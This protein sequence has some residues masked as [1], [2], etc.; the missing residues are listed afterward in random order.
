[1]GYSV[2]FSGT[3]L[4]VVFLVSGVGKWFGYATFVASIRELRVLP[5]SA[6]PRAA[7]LVIAAEL[8]IASTLAAGMMVEPALRAYAF[9]LAALM[10]AGFTAVIVITLRRGGSGG[11]AC[12][13]R[14]SSEFS[15]R[16]L[17]RNAVL[18]VAALAG[19]V[20]AREDLG[21]WTAG[22]AVAI[23]AGLV[24][25]LLVVVMDDVVDLFA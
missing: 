14:R 6:V 16:H 21:A 4:I 8:G 19:V 7:A 3:L 1:M 9:V 25:S 12:F 22:T 2:V 18:L 11:C 5:V 15:G 23:T 17:V 24:L 13:G 20:G 10:L